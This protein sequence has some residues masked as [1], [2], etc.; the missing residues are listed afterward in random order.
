MTLGAGVAFGP[1]GT[2]LTGTWFAWE[3]PRIAPFTHT[4]ME[5]ATKYV[6]I[7]CTN[8]FHA[9]SW[10]FRSKRHFDAFH[11]HFFKFSLQWF[12][13]PL[14][15]LGHL[16]KGLYEFCASPW[17]VIQI[18][19]FFK[20]QARTGTGDRTADLWVTSLTLSPTP[21]GTPTVFINTYLRH[22]K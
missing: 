21:R 18:N 20:S 11:L 13:C 22:S 14:K 19:N 16:N 8:A 15:L 1:S 4:Y 9:I 2:D 7:L 10:N 17:I 12:E 3:R 5:M 6:G